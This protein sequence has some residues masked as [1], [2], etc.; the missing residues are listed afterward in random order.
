MKTQQP[1]SVLIL[2]GAGFIGSNLTQHLLQRT[3]AEVHVFDNISRP[4]VHRN[5]EW[6][7]RNSPGS[8]RLRVTLGDVRDFDLVHK[9]VSQANEIYHFAAQVAVTTSILDPRLDF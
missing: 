5:L 9:A 2:G 4:G 8:R 7:R 3:D 6:L 1:R